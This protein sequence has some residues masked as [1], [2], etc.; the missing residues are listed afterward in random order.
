MY[1]RSAGTQADLEL[2][3]Q[4]FAAAVHAALCMEMP[5]F[6]QDCK[7]HANYL[8]EPSRHPCQVRHCVA[9]RQ[10]EQGMRAWN[11]TC[12]RVMRGAAPPA[13]GAA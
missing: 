11:L 4:L 12:S 13:W 6:R 2:R 8:L 3:R 1:V 5:A 10:G 7:H 9:Y